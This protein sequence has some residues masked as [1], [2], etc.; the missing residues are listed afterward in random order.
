MRVIKTTYK[1]IRNYS[2]I[3]KVLLLVDSYTFL[4]VKIHQEEK[5]VFS[6]ISGGIYEGTKKE[7][8]EYKLTLQ[9]EGHAKT[10][11]NFI[12]EIEKL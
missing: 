2:I 11:A 12:K 10:T 4:D 3:E 1:T 5:K 7:K 6:F 9:I 8:T